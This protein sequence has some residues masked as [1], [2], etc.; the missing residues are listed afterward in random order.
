MPSSIDPL[1]LSST[2]LQISAVGSTSPTQ[3]PNEPPEQLS[4]PSLHR[5]MLRVEAGVPE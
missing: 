4:A 1:Q 2:V 5:P 3:L